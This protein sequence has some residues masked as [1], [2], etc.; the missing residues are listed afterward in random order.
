[1]LLFLTGEEEIEDACK[2]VTKEC[3]QLGD[4]VCVCVC[5]CVA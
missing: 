4:K 5:A 2:K 1:V 3:Q